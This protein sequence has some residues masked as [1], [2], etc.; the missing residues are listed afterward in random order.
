VRQIRGSLKALSWVLRRLLPERKGALAILMYHRVTGDSG[1]EL[2]ID[3]RD[4]EA[5]MRWLA[6]YGE[7]VSL[8]DALN[9]AKG[10]MPVAH[11]RP[12][13]VLT[14]DDAFRDFYTHAWPI[15]RS[16]GLPSTLYVPTGFVEHPER[17]P[18]SRGVRRGVALA[19]VSWDMLEELVDSP[20]VTIGAHTHDHYELPLL[21]D[22]R[23]EEEL[24]QCDDLLW[25]RLGVQVEHF[26]YPRGLWDERVERLVKKRYRSAVHVGGGALEG[27]RWDR[28][29]LPR[30]PVQASDRMRWFK[31]RINGDLRYEESAVRMV[32]RLSGAGTSRNDR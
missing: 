3:F 23:I 16:F 22:D 13:F 27:T 21:S 30:I 29:R 25:E 19:P 28:Y 31:A 9:G 10:A 15:L 5:Q 14:F 1:L 11:D 12:T 32:K 20:L 6:G 17:V 8:G 2:D 4:F 26:A 18:L 7:V 24:G